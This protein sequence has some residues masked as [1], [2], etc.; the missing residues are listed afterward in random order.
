[1]GRLFLLRDVSRKIGDE[2]VI[3]IFKIIP[4]GFFNPLSSGSNNEVNASC[5]I[6]IYEQFENEVTY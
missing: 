2:F 1:M 6:E 3:E 5:L 4:S